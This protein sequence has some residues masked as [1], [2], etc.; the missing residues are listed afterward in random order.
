MTTVSVLNGHRKAVTAMQFS[1]NGMHLGSGSKDT[2]V[3]L[4]D[5]VAEA[6]VCRFKGHKDEVTSIVFLTPPAGSTASAAAGAATSSVAPRQFLVTASKDTLVKVWDVVAQSCVQTVIGARVE[7]WGLWVSPSGDRVVAAAGDNQMRVWSAGSGRPSMRAG[8]PAGAG[9]GMAVDGAEEGGASASAAAGAADSS[10]AGAGQEPVLQPMGSVTRQ[11]GERGVHVA[12]SRDGTLIAVQSAGKMVEVYRRRDAGE[13]RKRVLRRLQ[14]ARE[15]LRQRE[16]DR[17]AAAATGAAAP[18]TVDGEAGGD[19]GAAAGGEGG[20]LMLGGTSLAELEALLARAEREE[21]A[22]AATAA[23]AGASAGAVAAGGA[24]DTFVTAG[25]EWELIG[26]AQ[27]AHKVAWCEFLQPE[28]TGSSGAVGARSGGTGGSSIT[29]LLSLQ[30]NQVQLHS[31]PLDATAQE[32]LGATQLTTAAGST[33]PLAVLSRSVAQQGHRGDVRAVAVSSDSQLLL[34][35]SVGQAKVWNAKTGSCIRTLDLGSEAAVALCC[36]FGPGDRHALVGTKAGE[37]LLFDLASGDL[38]ERHEAH[39]GALWS[40]GVRP[41]GKGCAT[42]SADKSVKFWD[43]DLKAVDAAGAAAGAGKGGKDA[44]GKDKGKADAAAG[45]GA[46]AAPALSQLTLVHARTLK[47]ADEV[48]CIKYSHH[49]DPTRLLF[50]AALLDTTVKV[51]FE[52]TLRFA[53]SL[54]GHKLP[55]MAMDIS[56]DSSL[57][58]TASA[59]KNVKLWGLDFGDCHRSFFAHADSVMGVAFIA[60]THLFL[61]AGKDRVIK[62]WDG[63]RFEHVL[64]MEGHKGEAWALAVARDGSFFVTG[65]HDRSLRV[66]RRS[67]EQVFVEEEREREMDALTAGRQGRDPEGEDMLGGADEVGA[68]GPDGV[69]KT[70]GDPDAPAVAGALPGMDAGVAEASGVVAHATADTAKGTDRLLEALALAVEETG[71]W[72]E[73]A[74]DVAAAKGAGDAAAIESI[75]PP[76]RNP[77]LLGLTPSGFVLRTLRGIRPSDVDQV[78]LLL[79]FS[80]AMRLLRY[81]LL[82]LRHGQ[83]VELCSRAALLILRVHHSQISSTRALQ[84]LVVSLKQAMQGAV[85]GLKDRVGFNLAGLRFLDSAVAAPA[86]AGL[87]DAGD[88]LPAGPSAHAEISIGKRKRIAVF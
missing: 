48:L 46:A 61:T 32:A 15:K 43:F 77:L 28:A 11:T 39:T 55:V 78:L 86:T 6:G 34:S 52:D 53:L 23:G 14:R 10:A 38:L 83:G 81:L 19:A 22:A 9:A 33:I 75:T 5:V 63:D 30:N 66:W 40:L 29:M 62:Y 21:A 82:L 80:D 16:R 42:G 87:G 56:A 85:A 12:G 49:R 26:A 1:A 72:T 44:K 4:W 37:L 64:T 45:A 60:N 13:T 74:Q 67:E 27:A 18:S 65:G 2:N 57:L 71:R 3:I 24:A 73:Y 35:G 31:L 51:F 76:P 7:L 47:L 8:G 58:V 88:R 36:S 68:I 54:Y 20:E 41:D 70:G 25:D 17:A 79:P 84:P 50:A 69:A 59:D